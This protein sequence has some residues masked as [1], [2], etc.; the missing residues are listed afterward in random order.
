MVTT[1]HPSGWLYE[2]KK[3]KE[4]EKERKEGRRMGEKEG[5]SEKVKE[6]G[7]ENTSMDKDVERWNICALLIRM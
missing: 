4:W 3:E 1:S 2:K 5:E 7:R 6:E